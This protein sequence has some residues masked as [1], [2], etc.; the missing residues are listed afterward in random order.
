VAV[1][2]PHFCRARTAKRAGPIK[3]HGQ[4]GHSFVS[5]NGNRGSPGQ[6]NSNSTDSSD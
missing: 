2:P 6:R 1:E 4:V 3:Q 5:L